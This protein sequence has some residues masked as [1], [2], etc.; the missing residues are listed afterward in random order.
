MSVKNKSVYDIPMDP[1]TDHYR[2]MSELMQ[3]YF[4]HKKHKQWQKAREILEDATDCRYL[5]AEIELAHLYKTTPEPNIPNVI[6][7]HKAE[8][9]YLRLLNLLDLPSHT[10]GRIALE[11]VDLYGNYMKRPVGSLSMLFYTR[12][13]GLAIPEGTLETCYRQIGQMDIHDFGANA[14]DT[15]RLAT[16]LLSLGKADRFAEMLLRECVDTDD[17]L[18]QGMAALS[19]ADF[20][21]DRIAECAAYKKEAEYYYHMAHRCGFPAYL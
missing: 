17:K 20:Y 19:L 15:L 8:H 3:Q 21:Y 7:Y 16:E 10:S 12:R 4:Y 1:V 11:L 6:R 9:I 5:P 18:L 14:A 13:M 2:S